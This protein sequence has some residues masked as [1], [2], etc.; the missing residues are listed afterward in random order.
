MKTPKVE[1]AYLMENE[2]H[3]EVATG[4]PRFMEACNSRRLNSALGYLSPAHLED[5]H[6]RAM[7]KNAAWSWPPTGAH[8]ATRSR[9]AYLSRISKPAI[10]RARSVR[11]S[12]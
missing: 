8:F 12:M 11:L 10:R 4:V 5:R 1:D 7:D 3:E 2:I 6:A 9:C